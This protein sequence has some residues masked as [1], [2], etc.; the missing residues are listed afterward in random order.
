[1]RLV[2]QIPHPH[3]RIVIH[4]YNG[5]YWVE[6]EGGRCKQN[7]KFD[8]EQYALPAIEQWVQNE[9]PFVMDRMNAMHENLRRLTPEL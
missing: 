7:F 6:F 8:K 1:M 3:L 9:I 5:K 4:E 2:N